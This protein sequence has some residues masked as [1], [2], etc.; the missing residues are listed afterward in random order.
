MIFEY[1]VPED[2]SLTFDILLVIQLKDIP[3]HPLGV[4]GSTERKIVS[5]KVF[6]DEIDVQ[7]E[8]EKNVE[9]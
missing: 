1:E 3:R 4:S 7:K 5:I 6:G 8:K 9:L 2:T